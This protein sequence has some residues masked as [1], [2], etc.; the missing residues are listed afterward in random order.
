MK[1]SQVALQLYTIRDTCG[2]PL[3]FAAS[4]KKVREI[5]YQAVQVSGV[6]DF[7][8]EEIS[9]ILTGEGLVC[10]ATHESG[11]K[12]LSNPAAIIDRLNILNCQNTAYPYPDG[13]DFAS[14]S[15]V[16]QLISGLDAAGA[17][18][19]A[20]GKTLSYHNHAMEFA[21]F[22]KQIVL[23]AIYAGTEPGNLKAE[24]DTYWVQYGGANPVDWC[25]KM[26]GRL[27]VLHLKDYAFGLNNQP[28]MAEIGAGNIDFSKVIPA[29]EKSGC[30][31]F[32][33]EQDTCPGDPF[34][35][36]HQSYEFIAANLAE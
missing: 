35:S 9:R 18:L 5:G 16:T 25:E 7:P 6:G 26:A 32:V 10:C 29:A 15:S 11:K 36:A 34:D 31:W 19:R 24:L 4:M 23:E 33:V 30:K 21:P 14:E 22:G 17:V 20:S 27:E 13:I 3:E 28:V 2:T 8:V 1:L 12:I